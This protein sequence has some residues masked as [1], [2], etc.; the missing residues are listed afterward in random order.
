MFIVT[1]PLSQSSLAKKGPA[2]SHFLALS[3]AVTLEKGIFPSVLLKKKEG[4]P[5]QNLFIYRMKIVQNIYLRGYFSIKI[6]NMY[7]YHF[8][9]PMPALNIMP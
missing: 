8:F 4:L 9:Y 7:K 1:L 5:D 2:L 6:V 3:I